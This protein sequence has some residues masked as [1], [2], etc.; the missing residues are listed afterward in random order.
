MNFLPIYKILA[1]DSKICKLHCGN[2]T[3]RQMWL[4]S[5]NLC[6]VVAPLWIIPLVLCSE[7]RH[8][9]EGITNILQ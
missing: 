4:R 6:F 9:L 8:I 1:L 3:E 5:K 7:L 2:T